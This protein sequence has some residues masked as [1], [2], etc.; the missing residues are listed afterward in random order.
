MSFIKGLWRKATGGT[1]TVALSV[2]AARRSAKAPVTID[3]AAKDE[4]VSVKRVYVMLRCVEEVEIPNYALP[5][6]PSAAASG[7][8][9]APPTDNK[10]KT[11]NVKAQQNLF[12]KEFV[13][14]PGVELAPNATRKFQGEVEIPSHLPPSFNGKFARV[15]WH[16]LA[17]LSTEGNDPDSGWQELPVT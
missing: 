4:P 8:S 5:A 2:G 17:G 15:K 7:T 1:A 6:E 3:V 13:L 16:V 12:E 10:P 14:S 9:S 11:V